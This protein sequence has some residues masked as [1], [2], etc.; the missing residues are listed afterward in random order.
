[1]TIVFIPF[2]TSLVS[3]YPTSRTA[4]IFYALSLAVA[5]IIITLLFWYGTH[6]NRLVDKVDKK[7]YRRFSFGY[8]NMAVIFLLSIPLSFASVR[9]AKYLWLLIIPTNWYIDH[10]MLE[11]LAQRHSASSGDDG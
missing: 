4:F 2:P 5:G 3:Q 7:L 1:M 11:K 9:F 10:V 6:D 8:L